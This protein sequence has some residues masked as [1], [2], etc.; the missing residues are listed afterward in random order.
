MPGCWFGLLAGPRRLTI[1]QQLVTGKP[2]IESSGNVCR[3]LGF[4]PEEAENFRARDGPRAGGHR[5]RAAT[6]RKP[7]LAV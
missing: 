3:D 7:I 2:L 6:D 5:S 4:S 1:G